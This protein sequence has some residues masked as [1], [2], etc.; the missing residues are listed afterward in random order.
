MENEKK[1]SE[2]KE[3]ILEGYH[4][5]VSIEKIR[6]KYKKELKQEFKLILP[7]GKEV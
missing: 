6:E 1:N 2:I 4:S 5:K 7:N 3:I